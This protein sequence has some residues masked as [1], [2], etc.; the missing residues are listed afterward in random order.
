MSESRRPV[1]LKSLI[2]AESA[3]GGEFSRAILETITGSPPLKDLEM[4]ET[5][6]EIWIERKR[7]GDVLIRARKV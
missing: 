1:N 6:E 3:T 7:T 2:D 4:V 5:D